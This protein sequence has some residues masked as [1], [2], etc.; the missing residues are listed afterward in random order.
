[1]ASRPGAVVIDESAHPYAPNL[2]TRA[3]VLQALAS[4]YRRIATLTLGTRS[5]GL[6]AS[7]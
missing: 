1:M 3:V 2:R 5:F 6:F 4:H 7:R